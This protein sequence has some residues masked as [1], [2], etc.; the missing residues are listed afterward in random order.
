[1][2]LDLIITNI[3]NC[4]AGE[5]TVVIDYHACVE[6][7]AK[8]PSKGGPR[9]SIMKSAFDSTVRNCNIESNPTKRIK[10]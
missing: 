7:L 8:Y 9:S 3:F 2:T 6:Y 5:L 4:R 1:M 10:R